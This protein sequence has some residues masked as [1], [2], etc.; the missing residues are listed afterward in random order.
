MRDDKS[1]NN[2]EQIKSVKNILKD[3]NQKLKINKSKESNSIPEKENTI[4]M[5]LIDNSNIFLKEYNTGLFEQYS[6]LYFLRLKQM[7]KKLFSLAKEK[8]QNVEIC[9]NVVQLEEGVKF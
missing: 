8:W 3:F 7:R 2:Q 1:F 6:D 5:E 9:T 4:G